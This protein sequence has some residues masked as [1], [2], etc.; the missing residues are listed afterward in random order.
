MLSI[1]SIQ[2]AFAS[3]LPMLPCTHVH[4]II[5]YIC[6][7]VSVPG[8]CSTFHSC[9]AL[10]VGSKTWTEQGVSLKMPSSKD[11][12]PSEPKE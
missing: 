2:Q 5:G 1:C 10:R 3:H 8:T 9:S 11:V 6:E 4:D 7:L 12:S